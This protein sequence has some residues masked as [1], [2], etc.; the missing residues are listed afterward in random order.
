MKQRITGIVGSK[1]VSYKDEFGS[2]ETHIVTTIQEDNITYSR[3][4][5]I[6]RKFVISNRETYRKARLNYL[7]N[8]Y[9]NTN[10]E[11]IRSRSL[12]SSLKFIK[13]YAMSG[14][15]VSFTANF[16]PSSMNNNNIKLQGRLGK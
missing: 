12:K 11:N 6:A 8:R 16:L 1:M 9:E 4:N 3:W 14:E 10:L 2:I 13:R 15:E 7:Q 5:K